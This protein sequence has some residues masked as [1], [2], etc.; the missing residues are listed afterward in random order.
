MKEMIDLISMET[1]CFS[2]E[3]DSMNKKSKI[4]KTKHGIEFKAY[5]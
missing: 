5:E 2:S 4:R 1:K 3:K